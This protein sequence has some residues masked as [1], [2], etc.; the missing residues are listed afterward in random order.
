MDPVNGRTPVT[1]K[2]L[3]NQQIT[4]RFSMFDDD[5]QPSSKKL[6]VQTDWCQYSVGLD[7]KERSHRGVCLP[8]QVDLVDFLSS[9]PAPLPIS[10]IFPLLLA[11]TD[12]FS[13]WGILYM[14]TAGFGSLSPGTWI[15]LFLFLVTLGHFVLQEYRLIIV[16]GRFS[17]HSIKRQIRPVNRS[18]L[19]LQSRTDFR[20]HFLCISN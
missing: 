5:F 6:M 9:L 13:T 12:L 3:V 17:L 10:R 2:P 7:N 14:S 18:G 15:L 11:E 1:L 19:S 16:H 4:N 8:F 20:V